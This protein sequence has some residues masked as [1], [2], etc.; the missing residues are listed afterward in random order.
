M[1]Q[2]L[3]IELDHCINWRDTI[4]SQSN[5]PDGKTTRPTSVEGLQTTGIVINR[6]LEVCKTK[7][8]IKLK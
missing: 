1:N 3:E 2:R 4:K 6:D 5:T 8:K 7:G